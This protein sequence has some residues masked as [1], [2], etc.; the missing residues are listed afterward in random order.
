M[1]EDA[2]KLLIVGGLFNIAYGLLTG[3]PAAIIR[4]NSP[5]YSKYLRFVH[6]GALMW[7]PLLISLSLAIGLST[8]S[9]QLE[10]GAAILMVAASILLGAKDTLNWLWGVN[11]EFVEK[12]RLPLLMGSLSALASLI[13]IAILLIGALQGL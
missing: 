10:W 2:A 12:P 13:G 9:E 7:G 11:D 6:I 8:L 4:Q 1:M 3:I 5:S